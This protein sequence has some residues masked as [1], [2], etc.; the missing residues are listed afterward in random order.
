EPRPGFEALFAKLRHV[1]FALALPACGSESSN[2]ADNALAA[3]TATKGTVAEVATAHEALTS[4]LASNPCGDATGLADSAW[5]AFGRCPT[6]I[7]RAL[8]PGPSSGA[9][10]WSFTAQNSI[11]S[12]AAIGA[13]GTVYFGSDDQHLYAVSPDGRKLWSY[14]A[15]APIQSSPAVGRDG[16]IY[17]GSH[18]F[19]LH[20]VNPNGTP[21]WR[22]FT[23]GPVESSPI[24][25][26][27]GTIYAGSDDARLYA[28]NPNGT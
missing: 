17:V 25:G 26:A 20:A 4:T 16:T 7:G 3:H 5:P 2:V 21:K 24:V 10:L 27:D 12:S 14:A 1:V 22:F 8:A 9:P 19:S 23:L 11:R 28:V 6:R 13:D 15:F 18:D